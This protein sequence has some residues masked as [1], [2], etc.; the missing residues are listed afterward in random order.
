MQRRGGGKNPLYGESSVD[1]NLGAVLSLALWVQVV[2]LLVRELISDGLGEDLGL[3]FTGMGG[4]VVEMIE[5][6]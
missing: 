6:G 1:D 5:R 2:E 3:Q 4:L